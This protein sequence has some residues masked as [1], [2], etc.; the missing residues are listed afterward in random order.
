[1][2]ISIVKSANKVMIGSWQVTNQKLAQF[3]ITLNDAKNNLKK[4][5]YTHWV[6]VSFEGVGSIELGDEPM[7]IGDYDEY[8]ISTE[9]RMIIPVEDMEIPHKQY[10]CSTLNT[11]V[12]FQ[13]KTLTE[14]E[15]IILV[16]TEIIHDRNNS[17]A[18]NKMLLDRMKKILF[19]Y[20]MK[21]Y[22]DYENQGM[23]KTIFEKRVQQIFNILPDLE[24][25]IEEGDKDRYSNNQSIQVG[26][27]I[28]EEAMWQ[29]IDEYKDKIINVERQ[30]EGQGDKQNEET[31]LNRINNKSIQEI[32]FNNEIQNEEERVHDHKIESLADSSIEAEEEIQNTVK[33]VKL[34][35]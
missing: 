2:K 13:N 1:M 29:K 18:I 12:L 21:A 32:V 28:H 33:W 19:E 22:S 17:R 15:E 27:S 11:A 30:E 26:E 9:L 14:N 24:A 7:Y 10:I 8:P 20:Q 23:D 25:L 6:K 16:Y 3:M 4:R 35:I 34:D 31:A 5:R